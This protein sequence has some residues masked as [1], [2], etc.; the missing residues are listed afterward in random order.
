MS[1]D[2]NFD[3]NRLFTTEEDVGE[4]T[5]IWEVSFEGSFPLSDIQDDPELLEELKE[6]IV[7]EWVC[8]EDSM[9]V[10]SCD[11]AQVAINKVRGYM[12]SSDGGHPQLKDFKLK[13]VELLAKADI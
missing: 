1:V 9:T 4:A 6:D 10:L 11:D 7:G 5:S 13:G 8:I 3:L 2:K 12:E